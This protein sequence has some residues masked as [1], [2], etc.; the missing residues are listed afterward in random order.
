MGLT[1]NSDI[2]ELLS[3]FDISGP[4]YVI[5]ISLTSLPYKLKCVTWACLLLDCVWP[6]SQNITDIFPDVHLQ[7]R[8]GCSCC[9][10]AKACPTLQPYE[11]VAHQAPMFKGFPRQGY[12]SG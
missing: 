2:P 6:G 5:E 4:H 9:F 12:W 10:I 3:S 8:I 1:L 7:G 11:T